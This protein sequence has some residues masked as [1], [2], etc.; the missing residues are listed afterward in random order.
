MIDADI[1]ARPDAYP[2]V[3]KQD[4]NIDFRRVVNLR[5]FL[6][7]YATVLTTDTSQI[8]EWQPGDIVIFRENKHIGIVSDKRNRRGHPYIIHNGGQ[9][10]REEDYL[11]R[12]S[13]TAH[14]RFDTSRMDSRILKPWAD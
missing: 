13:V 2:G 4:K 6:D 10:V 7:T 5:V 11:R 12:A 8:G 9:P 1:A 3:S 14:Y